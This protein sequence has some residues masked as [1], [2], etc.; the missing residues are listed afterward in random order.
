MGGFLRV[1]RGYKF[2]AEKRGRPF[3][4]TESQFRELTQ[5]CCFYC[6]AKPNKLMSTGNQQSNYTYNGVDR[7]DNSLGYVISNCVPCCEFCNKAKGTRT[8]VEFMEWL[9]NL[10]TFR[11]SLVERIGGVG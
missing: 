8:Y 5:Q 6:G 3:E 11:T 9:A 4:L 1:Y 2:S 10:I 7:V